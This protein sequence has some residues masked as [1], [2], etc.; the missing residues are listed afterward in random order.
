MAASTT[1]LSQKEQKRTQNSLFG[2]MLVWFL[3]LMILYALNSVAC[4]WHWLTNTVGWMDVLQFIEILI[5]LVAL[6]MI[7]YLIYLPWRNW[8]GLQRKKPAQNPHLL[9]DT[10]EDR[11]ALLSF[12]AMGVNGF[13]SLFVIATLVLMFS[14]TAC[15]QI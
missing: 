2:G 5:S 7:G 13:F 6:A 11:G 9:E 14:F 3:D 10:Q 8:R 12:L 4:E 15:G 1:K